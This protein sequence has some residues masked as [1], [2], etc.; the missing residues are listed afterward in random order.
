[1]P[2]KR[3][4]IVE[5]EVIIAQDIKRSVEDLGYE[6]VGIVSNGNEAVLKSKELIPDLIMMDII[7]DG[8][9][10]GIEAASQ[11]NEFSHI[12]IIYL[13]SFSDQKTLES[14]KLTGPHGYIL[15]PF[16]QREL[17]I[18]LEMAFYR[19]DMETKLLDSEEKYRTLLKSIQSP[20][21]AISDKFEIL[22]CNREFG[23]LFNTK[24]DDLIGLDLRNNIPVFDDGWIIDGARKVLKSGESFQVEGKNCHK[25]LLSRIYPTPTGVLIIFNDISDRKRNERELFELN[26]HLEQRVS[27][28]LIKREKQR[29]LLIQKSKLESLGKLS[30]GIAHEINQP[31]SGISMGLDNV[32]FKINQDKL[33]P[34]YLKEKIN[35]FFE[36]INRIREIIRHIRIFSRDQKDVFSSRVDIN[37]TI[38]NA[39]S[40]VK[41]QYKNHQI[42]IKLDL[43]E[44]SC[45]TIGNKY[46]LEQVLLNLLSN[47]KDSI[48]EKSVSTSGFQKLI[49]ISSFHKNNKAYIKVTDNGMGIA[50]ED[51]E[52]IFEPFYTTKDEES[53]TGLGLSI[54]YGILEEMKAT[55]NVH[56]KVD[57]FTEMTI[58]M[59]MDD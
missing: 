34:S 30:A 49:E 47:A 45:Y 14:A 11:I 18:S 41:T 28:E 17:S 40:M 9:I 42:E 38:N 5:D 20:V 4:L 33:K 37:E 53:G 6:I 57:S 3:I 52:H 32:L 31:L 1:M 7:L 50:S 2:K 55:L 51:I 13:T 29:E 46:R 22:Y 56:S 16:E 27:E 35:S 24:L 12:P 15:K 59:I 36:D 26:N 43:V 10:T 21:C 39:L 54:V 48:E 44:G 23:E 58:E 25:D 19:K 8:D